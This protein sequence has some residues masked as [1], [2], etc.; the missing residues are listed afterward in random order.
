MFHALLPPETVVPR[1]EGRRQRPSL[2]KMEVLPPNI[3]IL[4]IDSA[5]RLNFK[6]F[7]TNT[8]QVLESLGAVEMLGFNKGQFFML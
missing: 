3:I 8:I 5:S 1:V 6:R 4:G 2:D 7:M